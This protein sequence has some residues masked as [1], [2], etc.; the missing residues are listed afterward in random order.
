MLKLR[1]AISGFTLA[2]CGLFILSIVV[3]IA[4]LYLIFDVLFM[5]SVKRIEVRDKA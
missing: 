1:N 4:L 5:P 2:L 3:P